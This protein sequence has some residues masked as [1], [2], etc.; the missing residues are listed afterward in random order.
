MNSDLI[1]AMANL[2]ED[3]AIAIVRK[4]IEEG[5]TAFDIVEQCRQGVEIVGKRY[6]EGKYY[7]SD[8]IMSEAILKEVMDIIEPHFPK[9]GS[10]SNNGTKVIMGTIEGDIH[11]LGKN[12]VIYLL[13]S[14]GYCVYDLGVN[15]PPERFVEAIKETGARIVGVCVLLTFCIG[16][17]KKLVDLLEETGLR[18]KVTIVVGGY[19]VDEQVKEYTGVDY[20]TNDG[21][22]AMEIF[23]Q[24]VDQKIKVNE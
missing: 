16:Y 11:D 23:N 20:V 1:D 17:V 10:A 8:L 7:L 2:E 3:K 5:E 4:K 15:V 22:I 13:R 9:L 12:I 6:S 18:E 21:V 14:S 19:P 24:I